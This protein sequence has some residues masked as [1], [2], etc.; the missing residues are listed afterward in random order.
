MKKSALLLISFLIVFNASTFAF[1]EE[2]KEEAAQ[3]LEE[4]QVEEKKASEEKIEEETT[5]TKPV[6]YTLVD[7]SIMPE[8]TEFYVKSIFRSQGTVKAAIARSNSLRAGDMFIIPVAYN[9]G[10]KLTERLII[11]DIKL[12]FGR[13]IEIQDSITGREYILR[14]SYGN[15]KSRLIPKKIQ[16]TNNE[17]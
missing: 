1:A 5:N 8:E 7:K 11:K 13:H 4:K 2:I 17:T 16:E 15:A 12:G 6:Y 14:M 9:K 10:D 3:K